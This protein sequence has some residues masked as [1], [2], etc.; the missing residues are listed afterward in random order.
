MYKFSAPM[1]YKKELIDYLININKEVEKSKITSLYFSLPPNC[2]L[3]SIFEQYRN[4]FV[5]KSDFNYWKDLMKY[6]RDNGFDFIYNL[7]NPKNLPVEND[8]FDR[9][10]EKL[11][12][13]LGQ[14]QEIGVNKLRISNH[15]LLSYINMKYRFFTLYASTS[16]EYKLI[17]E[18]QHF[19]DIHPEVKQI[20]P[21]HDVNKNFELLKNL[22]I[23][24]PDINIELIVNEGCIGGCSMRF[25][26][27]CEIMNKVIN[28][29]HS[30]FSNAYHGIHCLNT[31]QKAPLI[32]LCKSQV[33]YPW[34]IEEYAKIGINNFKIAGREDFTHH[35]NTSVYSFFLY[36]KG[37]DNTKNIEEES[38]NS[39]I[40]HIKYY[41]FFNQFK[42]K[43]IKNLLPNINHFIKKGHLCAS[44]CDIKC[45]YCYSCAEKIKKKYKLG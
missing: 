31:V 26:D 5:E 30:A 40:H 4:G 38:I 20:V 44:I 28:T 21:S 34:E 42:I 23:N 35:M 29:K 13:L 2:E 36:L 16:F 17:K 15:K 14:L 19:L 12:I 43:D 45:K 18:Y 22:R 7:N 10:L 32:Y 27:S 41:D 37:I 24:K 33:I 6:S 3:F 25:D 39:I 1:P 9:E 11:D 8:N